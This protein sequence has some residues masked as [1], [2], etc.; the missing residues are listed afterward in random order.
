MNNKVRKQKFMLYTN[1]NNVT[2]AAYVVWGPDVK[3][4]SKVAY[5]YPGSYKILYQGRG[6]SEDAAK[7]ANSMFRGYTFKELCN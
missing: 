6:T 3:E 4:V 5:I 7:I 2:N 1:P